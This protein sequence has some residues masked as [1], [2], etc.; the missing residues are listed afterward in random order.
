VGTAILLSVFVLSQ[1]LG[2]SLSL[3]IGVCTVHSNAQQMRIQGSTA[4]LVKW[5]RVTHVVWLR[6]GTLQPAN[7]GLQS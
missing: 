7:G 5:G 3:A 6:K 2:V 1:T 4:E